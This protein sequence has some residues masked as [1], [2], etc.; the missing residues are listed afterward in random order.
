MFELNE[1]ER[2]ESRFLDNAKTIARLYGERAQ[3][4]KNY[5]DIPTLLDYQAVLVEIGH[6]LVKQKYLARELMVHYNNQ[7]RS[8]YSSAM[9]ECELEKRQSTYAKAYAT[10]KSSTS[11]VLSGKW[12]HNYKK[13][14]DMIKAVENDQISIHSRYKYMMMINEGD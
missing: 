13:F 9:I 1:L 5:Q 2:I 11:Q 10:E 8:D 12:E 6:K 3:L 4:K 14:R 7:Y